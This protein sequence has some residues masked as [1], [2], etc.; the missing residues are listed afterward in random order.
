MDD[1]AFRLAGRSWLEGMHGGRW[2][3]TSQVWT[4]FGEPREH[5]LTLPSVD[6]S[7]ELKT[8]LI[9]GHS[10][11]QDP[12]DGEIYCKIRQYD[13]EGNIYLKNRW[14]TRL[15]D[16][17]QRCLQQIFIHDGLRTAFDAL[18]AIPGLWG[19]MRISTLSKIITMKCD[20]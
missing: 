17:G 14:K 13:R 7:N 16:H 2:I 12:S 5:L 9:E 4:S 1:I 15:S 11:E 19:G 3:S 8:P 6:P 20:Q 18:L 10:N